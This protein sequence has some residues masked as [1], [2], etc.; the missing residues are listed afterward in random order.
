MLRTEADGL[1]AIGA[2]STVRTPSILGF[3][4]DD[5]CSVLVLEFLAGGSSGP[6]DWADF[7]ESLAALHAAPGEDRY[8]FPGDNFLGLTPQINTWNDDWVEFNIE[9]RLGPQVAS[10]RD[11][12]RLDAG[13]VGKLDSIIARLDRYLPRRPRSSLLHGDLWSGNAHPMSNGSI[14]VIDPACARG[15]AWADP[16]MML[17][18]GGFPP[19]CLEA[20]SDRQD[21]HD[22]SEDRIAIYQLYHLLNHLNLFGSS[23]LGQVMDMARRLA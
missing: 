8:G 13:Q 2:T 11:A 1:A 15:D 20:W 5:A 19:S 3:K 21:D 4:E 14:A 22:Q 16:A 7:G 18:F 9:C 23:Y 17:L 12:G 10:A 6:D